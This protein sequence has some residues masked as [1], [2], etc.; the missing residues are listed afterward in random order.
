MPRIQVKPNAEVNICNIVATVEVEGKG[1]V[2]EAVDHLT[3]Y[4]QHLKRPCLQQG[5]R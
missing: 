5:G 3:W 4:T 2:P 1:E